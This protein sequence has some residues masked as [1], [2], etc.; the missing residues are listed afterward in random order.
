MILF[1]NV[2]LGTFCL[3]LMPALIGCVDTNYDP[4]QK[5]DMTMGFDVEGL[6]MKVGSTEKIYLADVLETDKNNMLK[7]DATRNSLYY[8]E[9][10]Y[11]TP[12]SFDTPTVKASLNGINLTPP[13]S[14][15]TVPATITLPG[16][17]TLVNNQQAYAETPFTFKL[18]DIAPEVVSI[19]RIKPTTATQR[20]R[21]SASVLYGNNPDIF[22]IS[23]TGLKITFPSYIKC[24][25]ADANGSV[26]ITNLPLEITLTELEMPGDLGQKI[27]IQNGVRKFE[28][29][30]TLKMEGRFT[31]ST[32]RDFTF[33]QGEQI[34]VAV[35]IEPIA[36]NI[37][38]AE[39]T[40]VFNP[41]IKP[42]ISP[43]QIKE[44]L[45]G[46]LQDDATVMD[47]TNPTLYINADMRNIPASLQFSGSLT[48]KKS[49][50]NV[51]SVR[52]P[53]TG[54][55]M[56][57]KASM[58]ESYFSALSQPYIPSSP[59]T[60]SNVYIVPTLPQLIKTIPDELH[61]D[62]GNN[63]IQVVQTEPATFIPNKKYS[64]TFNYGVYIPLQFGGDMNIL[65]TD[66]VTN[67]QKD[68]K[69]YAATGVAITTLIENTIPLDL[70]LE[71]IPYDKAGKT[72]S[73]Q[74]DRATVKASSE[75]PVTVNI[76]LD[77]LNDLKRLDKLV[78]RISA[79]AIE[80]G[81]S[82]SSRQYIMLK[83]CRLHLKGKVI[84]DFN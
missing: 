12:F 38:V 7:T 40:G 69:D 52:L 35:R 22:N 64:G 10:G 31:L 36:N 45:P 11:S 59:T 70:N 65:Y 47:I 37:E 48:V 14:L 2:W 19:K 71:I 63:Q 3:F 80:A 53:D 5:I 28:M 6:Q 60:P 54:K 21:I 67:I 57:S 30:G 4:T 66:S 82:L 16:K 76:I 23:T 77:D 34:N 42:N 17:T 13:S 32:T 25:Q 41:S 51:S 78:F 29:S 50:K 46:F 15:M 44:Q 62:L 61:I 26:A 81:S 33:K 75:T 68:L 43:I 58:A 8:I 9:E 20:F 39:V 56:F 79:N 84:R 72:I 24:K 83:D 73:A 27:G 1:K 74:I 49:G 55:G 18:N